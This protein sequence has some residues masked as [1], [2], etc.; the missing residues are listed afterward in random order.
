MQL[1]SDPESQFKLQV[2]LSCDLPAVVGCWREDEKILGDD[3][4]SLLWRGYA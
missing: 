3:L 1:R 2:T 4:Q